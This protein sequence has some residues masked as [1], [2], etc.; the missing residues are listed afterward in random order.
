MTKKAVNLW[1][2]KDVYEE[3]KE[4]VF[5]IHG[6]LY[7]VLSDEATK[8]L[9]L[10]IEVHKDL[11]KVKVQ[12]KDVPKLNKRQLKL[13]E[14]IYEFDQISTKELE[15]I[16]SQN[17]GLDKRTIKKYTGFLEFNKFI[18]EKGNISG[19]K[20]Y[21]VNK[22]KIF[23]YLTKN[24]V[25]VNNEL[26][27]VKNKEEEEEIVK[28]LQ[29][30]IEKAIRLLNLFEEEI[31]NLNFND[32]YTKILIDYINK[33]RAVLGSA[34]NTTTNVVSSSGTSDTTST[35]A[36]VKT[37]QAQSKKSLHAEYDPVN[38]V[39]HL[40]C[41]NCHE[42]FSTKL[43]IPFVKCDH[44]GFSYTIPERTYHMMK[45]HESEMKRKNCEVTAYVN[46]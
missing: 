20:I 42:I 8:A 23:A 22:D 39:W 30:R 18:V 44:C 4:L 5:Q 40:E 6:R 34:E 38:D 9:E 17:I 14:L 11:S 33:V 1:I 36:K 35:K 16:I 45:A 15:E 46:V 7:G 28:N 29:E 12:Y 41:P 26:T 10:W 43:N 27:K 31:S 13:L 19:F 24:G 25:K 37:R 2:D 3:F 21:E 32:Y